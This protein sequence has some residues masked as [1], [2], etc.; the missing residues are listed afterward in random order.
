MIRRCLSALGLFALSGCAAAPL[1]PPHLQADADFPSLEAVVAPDPKFDACRVKAATLTQ[2]QQAGQLLMI[3]VDTRGLNQDTRNAIQ[4]TQ[5]GSVVLLGDSTVTK[6]GITTL[7]AEIGSLGSADL[8]ILI[9]VDQEGGQVQRLKG[10]GFTRIPTAVEQGKMSTSELRD[11]A[12]TWGDELR[13]AGVRMNLAP[14]ADVVPADNLNDNE[15]IAK[16][17]RHYSTESGPAAQSV[18]AFIEGMKAAGVATS[19]KHFPGLGQVREN[20]D[21]EAAHDTL[22]VN[23]DP[24]WAPF[25][26]GMEAG[27]SSVMISSAVFEQIDPDNQGVFSERIIT[28]ILRGDLDFRGVVIA[29][30]LGSAEAVSDVAPGERAVLFLRAGGDL[31]IDA[32]PKLANS[33]AD[34]ILDEMSADPAFAEQITDSVARVLK[35]KQ[36]VGAGNC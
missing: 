2:E 17:R 29:D 33:M 3:G 26:M 36:E 14:T 32:D 21:Y 15:P 10:A 8:P 19:V 16:L 9:A 1:L 28:E 12:K 31:V 13:S 30:D 18:E 20:T 7:S 6:M 34:A 35:M 5:A 24:L 22:T 27:A 23:G 25:V 4:S 11:A